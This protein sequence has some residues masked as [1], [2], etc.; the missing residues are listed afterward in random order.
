MK[1]MPFL[2]PCCIAIATLCP[3]PA[4]S[5]QTCSFRA[6]SGL[7]LNFGDL[8]PS[9]QAPVRAWMT[10]STLANMAGDCAGGT[11]NMVISINGLSTRQLV[12]GTA[13]ITYTITGF[14]IQLPKPGNNAPV[15][16]NVGWVTWFAGTQ[17]E[18]Q[19]Q[20]SA[21]ADAPAGLYTDNVT[22]DVT[23]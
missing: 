1:R 21:F 17:I 12:Q 2:I 5:G 19:I 9:V 4:W 3:L 7:S 22:I 23:P 15:G 16:S 18:G 10:S 20:W 6:P 14:P 11:P 8:D 13:S